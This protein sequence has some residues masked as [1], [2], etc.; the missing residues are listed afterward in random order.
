MNHIIDFTQSFDDVTES[1]IFFGKYDG[2]QRYD[3]S[4]YSIAD[5]LKEIQR[6]Q[7]WFPTEI[8]F[9][10]DKVSLQTVLSE[11]HQTIYRENLLFQTMADSLANRFLDNVLS[12]N[13]TS[14]DWEAV[15]KIQAFFELLHSEAYS[16]NIR[17]V[18]NDPE[19]LFNEGFKNPEIRKR[20][21]LELESYSNLQKV[22][23]DKDASLEDKKKA[24][25]EELLH[26]Y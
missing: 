7:I 11:E 14:P 6:A 4:R 20:L 25:L 21:D 26:Q 18:Y 19:K 8:N 23:N 24:M 17:Q 13:V 15:F 12:E 2:I 1:K 16:Y 3:R 5:K 22:L 9:S 10:K